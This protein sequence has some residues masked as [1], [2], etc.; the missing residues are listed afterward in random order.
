[1][2]LGIAIWQGIRVKVLGPH[3]TKP[4]T[5]LVQKETAQSGQSIFSVKSTELKKGD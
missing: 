4:D 1:M 3:E 2:K 5:W